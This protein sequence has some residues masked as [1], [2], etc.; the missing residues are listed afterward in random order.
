MSGWEKGNVPECNHVSFSV[1]LSLTLSLSL[2]G[3]KEKVKRGSEG[4]T[5]EQ[6]EECHRKY[7]VI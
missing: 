5:A 7:M 3:R 2:R 4:G 6:E 1:S